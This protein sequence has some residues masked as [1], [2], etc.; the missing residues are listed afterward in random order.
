M[1]LMRRKHLD[2]L[3]NQQAKQHTPATPVTTPFHYQPSV[4]FV[5]PFPSLFSPASP[6]PLSFFHHR[7]CFPHRHFLCHVYQW[8]I[9]W[10]RSS[11]VSMWNVSAQTNMK[12]KVRCKVAYITR[13]T[14]PNAVY[15][16]L[17]PP[18][19]SIE[20]LHQLLFHFFCLLISPHKVRLEDITSHIFF[21]FLF[22]GAFV[23]IFVK[24]VTV[25]NCISSN[26]E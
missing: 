19:T 3:R 26:I 22:W 1:C 20:P 2:Q 9:M 16:H 24:K 21:I 11:K 25:V 23:P 4:M 18:S 15:D 5:T 14:R 8:W 17:D 7:F 12:R 13:L 6:S 10:P